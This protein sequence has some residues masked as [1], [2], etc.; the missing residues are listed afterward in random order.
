MDVESLAE[1]IH[2][3]LC[4]A[5]PGEDGFSIPEIKQ[6]IQGGHL[7]CPSFQIAHML[8]SLFE[9]R[10]TLHTTLVTVDENGVK[11]VDARNMA[12]Y[13][14]VVSEISQVYRMGDMSK[15]LYSAEEKQ[16]TPN[17]QL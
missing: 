11:T 4:E 17:E 16:G 9:L 7:L 13:L 15:M 2:C 14:K 10:D 8:R 1:I 3:Q 5:A 12:N 6:H